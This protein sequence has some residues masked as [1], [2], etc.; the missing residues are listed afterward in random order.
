MRRR[1]Q[2][3]RRRLGTKKVDEEVGDEGRVDT[4]LRRNGPSSHR[5]AAGSKKRSLPARRTPAKNK[6]HDAPV[7]HVKNRERPRKT[8][9]SWEVAG[10]SRFWTRQYR[11][12]C[13]LRPTRLP[14][15]CH[16][17]ARPGPRPACARTRR[18]CPRASGLKNTR[19]LL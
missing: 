4:V 17:M 18:T 1:R 14:G 11:P 13:S 5:P 16:G 19:D 15:R 6:T 8:P 9:D 7:S 12:S 10:L 2:R 3:R